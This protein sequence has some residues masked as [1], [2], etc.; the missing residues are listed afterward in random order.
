MESLID[1]S[2]E[3]FEIMSKMGRLSFPAEY[4]GRWYGKTGDIHIVYSGKEGNIIGQCHTG[5]RAFDMADYE[6]LSSNYSNAGVNPKQVYL[7][8]TT[9]FTDEFM[10]KHDTMITPIRIE[11]L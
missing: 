10:T 4:K 2:Y 7:F 1:V 9:G 6:K 5:N 11:D 3:F 8:S